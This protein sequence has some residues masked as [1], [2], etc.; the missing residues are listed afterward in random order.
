MEIHMKWQLGMEE[1]MYQNCMTVLLLYTVCYYS[2]KLSVY[3]MKHFNCII[4]FTSEYRA[5]IYCC[6]WRAER[7]GNGFGHVQQ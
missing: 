6:S 2:I 4:H 3:K 5:V 1:L 7:D